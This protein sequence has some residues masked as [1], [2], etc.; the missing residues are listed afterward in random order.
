[1][2]TLHVLASTIIAL[3]AKLASVVHGLGHCNMLDLLMALATE[4]GDGLVLLG[5]TIAIYAAGDE[6]TRRYARLAIVAFVVV[7]VVVQS[8]KHLVGRERPLGGSLD[9]FPSG[10]TSEAFCVAWIWGDRWRKLRA[11]LFLLAVLVGFSRV[12]LMAHYPFDVIAGMALGSAGGV[13]AL[14]MVRRTPP[15]RTRP[16]ATCPGLQSRTE[17]LPEACPSLEDRD[18]HRAPSSMGGLAQRQS[19]EGRVH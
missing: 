13:V 18:Q 3:D 19:L 17:S 12:Y 11:T 15:R 10:H 1:M 2:A 8:V 7:G 14:A 9:S 16:S 4:L 5:I 6:S